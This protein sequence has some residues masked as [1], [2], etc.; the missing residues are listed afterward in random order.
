MLGLK[1]DYKV[2]I[3]ALGNLDAMCKKAS[4]M[5]HRFWIESVSDK[6]VH[7]A[8]SN[9]DEYGNEHPMIALFPCY[10]PNFKGYV[11]KFVVLETNRILHDDHNGEGWQAFDS[12]IVTPNP[13]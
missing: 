5:C 6:Y 7:V 8:Y 1:A 12:L 13:F 2:R 4:G 11:S 3:V 10:N 9:P